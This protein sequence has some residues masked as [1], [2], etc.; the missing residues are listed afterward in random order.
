MTIDDDLDLDAEN[1]T[2]YAF[3]NY[4]NPHCIDMEEFND[5]LNRFKYLK[6]LINKYM[7]HG[8]LSERL[9][10]NHI[11]V[12]Y[13]VFGI[14]AANKMMEFKIPPMQWSVVK[15][16]LLFLKYIKHTDYIDVELNKDAVEAL[17]DIQ[18]GK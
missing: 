6:K 7:E 10:L 12:I 17:R 5:D 2:L 8:V 9:I 3:R 1:F 11:I 14:E 18:Y 15:P 4:S 16:F 13:N